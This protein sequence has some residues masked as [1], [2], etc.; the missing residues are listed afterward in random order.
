MVEV[1]DVSFRFVALD[2]VTYSQ[3]RSLGAI[4]PR[5]FALL[6]AHHMIKLYRLPHSNI[7]PSNI[8]GR[9][10]YISLYIFLAKGKIAWKK[11]KNPRDRKSRR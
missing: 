11:K 7:K 3:D 1:L 2:P 9:L 6:S 8:Y 4:S 10:L 5:E